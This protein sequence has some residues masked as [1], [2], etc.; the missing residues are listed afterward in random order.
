MKRSFLSRLRAVLVTA[1]LICSLAVAGA[2]TAYYYASNT[3]Q[4]PMAT[5]GTSVYLQEVF[6]KD[7]KWLP[8]ETKEKIVRFGN[9]TDKP[10]VLRF[11]ATEGWLNGNA[12]WTPTTANPIQLHWTAALSSDW[13]FIDGWYYYKQPLAVGS[14]TA[15]VLDWAKFNTTLSNDGHA[16]DF[17][18]KTFRLNVEM[19]TLDVN[20][21]I[22]SLQWGR[23]FTGT[24]AL[25]WS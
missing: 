13:T 14:M 5:K 2:T 1:L 25:V 18:G 7:D 24:S 6:N 22:T 20:T 9:Q 17:S 4:N 23:S 10:Q 16:E 19:E 15:P 21:T 3:T 11:R 8:G 12:A